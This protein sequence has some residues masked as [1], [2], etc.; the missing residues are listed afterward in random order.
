[1]KELTVEI[2][3]KCSLDCLMCST[4]AKKRGTNHLSLDMFFNILNKYDDFKKVRLSGGEPFEHPNLIGLLKVLAKKERTA[5]ILSC[6][7][8]NNESIPEQY[9][10]KIA[11]FIDEILFSYHGF[12]DEHERIVT[13][14]KPFHMTYPYWDMLM[15]SA[16]NARNAGISFSF[17]TVLLKQNYN[18]L[19]AIAKDIMRI[20]KIWG[21]EINWHLLKFVKQGKGKINANQALNGRE[22]AQLPEIV[23]ELRAKYRINITYTHSFDHSGC[24]CG[25]KKA[26]VT[27]LGRE[28]PCSALKYSSKKGKYAC[29][30][31]V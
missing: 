2:T 30:S 21:K 28:I 18:K 27:I 5:Q 29:E 4:M 6:G 17:Q 26:T 24:D 15:D 11:P 20:N 8:R 13:S 14:N 10:E 7:V 31:R 23:D 25:D 1:M 16:D 3:D 22:V 12:Y 9:M 19:E